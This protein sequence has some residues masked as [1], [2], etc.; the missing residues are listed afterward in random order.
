MARSRTAAQ[1]ATAT[2]VRTGRTH[3]RNVRV[4]QRTTD[5]PRLFLQI[6][7]A[8]SP[9]VGTT[10]PEIVLPVPAGSANMDSQGYDYPMQGP[11]GGVELGTALAYAVTTTHDGN[12]APDAGDE[13]EVII[14][15]EPL[16]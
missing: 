3:L 5:A 13:P 6:F 4:R 16:G 10:A 2:A 9:T 12:T 8:A 7:N 14:D 11:R 15:Y 1:N